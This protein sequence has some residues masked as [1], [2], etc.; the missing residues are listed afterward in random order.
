MALLSKIPLGEKS[1]SSSRDSTAC[2]GLSSLPLTP[3]QTVSRIAL[4]Y[5]IRRLRKELTRGGWRMDGGSVENTVSANYVS[6]RSGNCI[7][8]N[9][10]YTK[11]KQTKNPHLPGPYRAIQRYGMIQNKRKPFQLVRQK[12]LQYTYNIKPDHILG[13]PAGPK[14]RL[15][16]LCSQIYCLIL[17]E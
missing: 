12:G 4:Q 15:N 10:E 9:G 5:P 3:I 11:K 1:P 2:E 16:W 14:D 8:K 17:A 6:K 7:K 13:F